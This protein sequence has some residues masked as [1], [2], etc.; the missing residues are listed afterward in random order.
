M[1]AAATVVAKRGESQVEPLEADEL[2]D[3]RYESSSEPEDVRVF[4]GAHASRICC[5][6]ALGQK[7]STSC[8]HTAPSISRSTSSGNRL[9]EGG[10]STSNS[11]AKLKE[12]DAS[13]LKT[14][15]TREC[16]P[17]SRGTAPCRTRDAA[18]S[19]VSRSR[20]CSTLQEALNDSLPRQSLRYQAPENQIHEVRRVDLQE[21]SEYLYKMLVQQAKIDLVRG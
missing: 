6:S 11:E 5:V 16:W 10:E 8:R 2:H 9:A 7:S 18:W 1:G 19:N 4:H 20:R 15:S 14:P 17:S 12:D 21:S 13:S 3:I